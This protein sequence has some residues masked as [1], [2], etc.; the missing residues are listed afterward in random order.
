MKQDEFEAQLV[1]GVKAGLIEEEDKDKLEVFEG[2]IRI[3]PIPI[4]EDEDGKPLPQV[5]RDDVPDWLKH[6]HGIIIEPEDK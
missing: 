2:K 6:F 4:E 1:Q 5:Q 3:K